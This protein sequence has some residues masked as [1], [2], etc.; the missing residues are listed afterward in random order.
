[1]CFFWLL[2]L[3]L[4]FDLLYCLESKTQIK[5]SSQTRKRALLSLGALKTLTLLVGE[6]EKSWKGEKWIQLRDVEEW[7]SDGRQREVSCEGLTLD[8]ADLGTF[9][10]GERWI[11]F[12]CFGSGV[13]WAGIHVRVAAWKRGD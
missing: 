1:M 11:W 2:R 10:S 6:K 4:H 13:E 8:V 3:R 9:M 5:S 12:V 7:F